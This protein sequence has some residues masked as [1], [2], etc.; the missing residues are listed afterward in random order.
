[1]GEVKT[2]AKT[3]NKS[4]SKSNSNSNSNDEI[5]GS[6]PLGCA[7]GQDDDHWSFAQDDD[8]V[9]D[10]CS[11]TTNSGCHSAHFFLCTWKRVRVQRI[12]LL[13]RS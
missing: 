10:G 7:Q 5:Q 9:G 13:T 8:H 4:K 1:M 6:F 2:K 3:K 12:R 11:E